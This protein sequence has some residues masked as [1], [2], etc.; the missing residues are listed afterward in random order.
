MP[1]VLQS[2]FVEFPLSFAISRLLLL[3]AG[4]NS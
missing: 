1:Y 3:A 4:H 2:C